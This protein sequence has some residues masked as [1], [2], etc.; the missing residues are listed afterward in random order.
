M[1]SS[2]LEGQ[3]FGKYRILEPLGRGGMARV[4]RAFHPHLN[5]YVAVKV[6]RSDL[7]EEGE[8]LARF[9]REAQAVAALRHTNII[10]VFD[11]DVQDDV[12]YIVMELLE[13]DTLKV[14][15][16]DYRVRGEKMPGGEVVRVLLDV[17]AGLAYAHSEGMIHRDIKPANILLT[18]RGEAVLAD[19]GIAQIVGG[20]RHTVSGALMGT[21]NYMAP[22]QGMSGN[23]DARS[24]IYS[25]GIVFYEMLTQ[26]TPF[27]ADT[28]LAILMK[29]LNEPL[30]I[31][32]EIDQ[33]IPRPFERVVLKSL[34]KA[35]EDRYQD[36]AEMAEDLRLAAA[37]AGIQVPTRISLPMSFTTPGAP[38]ESVAVFS[39]SARERIVE[40]DFAADD[41]SSSLP[42]P[43]TPPVAPP[44]TNAAVRATAIPVGVSAPLPP[45]PVQPA[46]PP[47]WEGVARTLLG[48][49]QE[50][51]VH[52]KNRR[53]QCGSDL[54]KQAWEDVK[55]LCLSEFSMI[56]DEPAPQGKFGPALFNAM[57]L[58]FIFNLVMLLFAGIVNNYHAVWGDGWPWELLLATAGL[59][60]L[61]RAKNAVWMLIPVGI[62]GG[63]GLFFGLISTLGT[64]NVMN[65]LWPVL[66][67]MV[68]GVVW[69]T[70]IVSG[71]G[72]RSRWLARALAGFIRTISIALIFVIMGLAMIF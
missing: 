8:F 25:L 49:V 7:V 18:K 68:I 30:P 44:V 71:H 19:F 9:R 40:A 41:T 55:W 21:L 38:S 5:R 69:G 60:T 39:G 28:P 15:L 37:E 20:T 58:F 27:D 53:P 47:T 34:A 42:Q 64:W 32:H 46:S 13:G 3:T 1:I 33:S 72:Q 26:T 10:Q 23:C 16:N 22:E 65:A 63:L 43:I 54:F 4:Y 48:G 50:M 24:D 17:L 12:Y 29:H 61:M 6:L 67:L 35:P 31:L 59:C 51:M 66:P 11:F 57:A 45:A 62:L 14:R 36:A 70:V 56:S 2:A 52:P